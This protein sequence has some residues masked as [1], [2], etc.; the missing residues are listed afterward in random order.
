MVNIRD[1]FR[2]PTKEQISVRLRDDIATPFSAR[3]RRTRWRKSK[4][5]KQK[6]E[7][8]ANTFKA[9]KEKLEIKLD[10]LTEDYN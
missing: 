1:E 10:L 2:T 7:I 6:F 8:I 5:D 3:K 4:E 9:E